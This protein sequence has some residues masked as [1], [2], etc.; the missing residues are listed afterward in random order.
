MEPA[1]SRGDLIVVTPPPATIEPGMIL[2]MGVD[3][4][5]V[6]HRVVSVKA[7]GSLVT[8]GDANDLDDDWH[9]KPVTV[10]GQY[11]FTIP[12]LGRVLPVN[13]ATGASFNDLVQ[14]SQRI[15]VGPWTP[16]PAQPLWATVWIEPGT[17]STT[18]PGNGGLVTVLVRSLAPPHRLTEIVPSSVELCYRDRCLANKGAKLERKVLLRATFARS[19][20]IALVGRDRGLLMFTV[21]GDVP[22]YPAGFA[23]RDSVRI[24]PCAHGAPRVPA[25]ETGPVTAPSSPGQP[26]SP[27][28]SATPP[29]PPV[30]PASPAPTDAPPTPVVTPP[31][32]AEPPTAEP[33]T[34][35]DPPPSAEP[36]AAPSPPAG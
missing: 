1:I 15:T 22:G 19:D 28:P 32:T 6:T 33:T 9:G 25:S 10:Y 29:A 2:T 18:K 21:Q 20:V 31:P 12:A 26:V 24:V 3:G 5:I 17:I 4:R 14:A 8:R 27:A 35:P 23:G 13:N 30:P 11:L 16:P 34:A 36:T 7:D